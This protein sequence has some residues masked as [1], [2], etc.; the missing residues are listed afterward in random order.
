MA[1]D[2]ARPKSI[3]SL[4]SRAAS[5]LCGVLFSIPLANV[6]LAE[7]AKA[8]ASQILNEAIPEFQSTMSSMSQG[9]GGGASGEPP[10]NWQG[11]QQPG[12]EAVKSL[13][14]ARVALSQNKIDDAKKYIEAGLSQWDALINS[15]AHSC[16]GGSSGLDPTYYGRYVGY[17]NQVRERMLTVLRFL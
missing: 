16:S 1:F 13:S 8:V 15:L 4:Q 5:F 10:L 17:K 6:A 9:C 11:R 3:R 2:I 14:D 7:D 12:N